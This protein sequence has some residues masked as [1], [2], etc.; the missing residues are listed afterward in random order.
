[1]Q[2][3]IRLLGPPRLLTLDGTEVPLSSRRGWALL[4]W[5]IQAGERA[6]PRTEMARLLW[7]D[8]GAEQ[9]RAS[10][11]QEL[12]V[13]RRALRAAGAD[14]I[15]ADKENLRY[16]GPPGLADA[17]E[18][19]RRIG[20][21]S[22]G[23][24]REA[25]ALYGGDFLQ[26][27]TLRSAAFT[28]WAEAE[29]AR[30]KAMAI[31]ALEEQV[32]AEA[33]AGTPGRAIAAAE[34]LLAADPLREGAYRALMQARHALGHRAEA[35]RQYELCRAHLQRDLQREPERD[36]IRLAEEI[37]ASRPSATLPETA[38]S[39][40][41]SI[42]GTVL[43]M[44]LPQA[45]SLAGDIRPDILYRTQRRFRD[46]A[47]R[48]VADLGGRLAPGA[49]DR[50]VAGFTG[51]DG[52]VQ[53]ALAALMIAGEP[54]ELGPDDRLWPGG[55]LAAGAVLFTPDGVAGV[56]LAVAAGCAALAGAGQV[57]ADAGLA[58]DLSGEFLVSDPVD[59]RVLIAPPDEPAEE[60]T[61]RDAAGPSGPGATPE[62]ASL[63]ALWHD[64][65][66]AMKRADLAG[67]VALAERALAQPGEAR[68]IAQVMLGAARLFQGQLGA[69]EAALAR[70][71]TL[72]AGAGPFGFDPGIA[73]RMLLAWT[74]SLRG[75]PGRGA[76][77][78]RRVLSEAQGAGDADTQMLC[79]LVAAVMQDDLG[80]T[81]AAL[82]AARQAFDDAAG[83]PHWQAMAMA[84]VG[85]AR[86]R[87]GDA[88][89]ARVLAEALDAYRA[90]GAALAVPF[91]HAWSAEA[92]LETGQT[93]EG[94]VLTDEGLSAASATGGGLMEPELLRLQAL[95]LVR[96]GPAD[97]AEA[98]F[99][100]A[101]AAAR[102]S[103]AGLHELRA[104]VSHAGYLRRM[105]RL[106]DA[107][108]RLDQGLAAVRSGGQPSADI[109]A[110]LTLKRRLTIA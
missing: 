45:A 104:S 4:A 67:A 26:G 36:T 89:G 81:R 108:A 16:I 47:A 38:D 6:V 69:A 52:P 92:C 40:A 46:Y 62:P 34:A 17:P 87:L 12:A 109:K 30:L 60:R 20:L 3:Q 2:A 31:G 57:V 70:A 24:L 64:W 55:G 22:L 110:A 97:A 72:V 43:V 32:R 5:L 13:I 25:A 86:D 28:A 66:A 56:P 105:G 75:A 7:P 19:E 61:G 27:V 84:L 15:D 101:L 93:G 88:S 1:M 23:D 90:S 79:R 21:G 58:A 85:R 48:M 11:R 77:D 9:A 94:L 74:R 50:V 68:S 37:R 49:A 82:S 98:G 10:L 51:E 80:E 59:G 18:M 39:G 100:A 83:R 99:A 103:G 14:R 106:H 8:S 91:I 65:R 95:M 73:G 44:H 41:E 35:L 102:R 76:E 42:F 71:E 78:L 53:A 54:M 96:K 33:E 107:A 63:D 29:R